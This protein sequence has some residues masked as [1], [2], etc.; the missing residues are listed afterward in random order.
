VLQ[1]GSSSTPD[2]YLMNTSQCEYIVGLLGS[3][4]CGAVVELCDACRVNSLIQVNIP[5]MDKLAAFHVSTFVTHFTS[6]EI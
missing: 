3:C 5:K 6:I 4:V 2:E 1:G